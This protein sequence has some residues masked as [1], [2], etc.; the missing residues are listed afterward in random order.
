VRKTEKRLYMSVQGVFWRTEIFKTSLKIYTKKE[1]GGFSQ[2]VQR[3][4][5][6]FSVFKAVKFGKSKRRHQNLSAAGARSYSQGVVL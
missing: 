1:N 4:N 3:E 5:V 6:V 2:A